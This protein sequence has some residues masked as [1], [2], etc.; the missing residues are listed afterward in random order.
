MRERVS[1]KVG[2][3]VLNGIGP[4]FGLKAVEVKL[5]R[6]SGE[7]EQRRYAPP[8]EQRR[9]HSLSPRDTA[10]CQLSYPS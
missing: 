4:R 10:M 8:R 6:E 2:E 1:T 7:A 5:V 3:N 9:R